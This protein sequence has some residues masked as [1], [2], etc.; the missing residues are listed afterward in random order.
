M[1][2]LA[3]NASE[4]ISFLFLVNPSLEAGLVNPLKRSFALAWLNPLDNPASLLI[5][6]LCGEAKKIF[7]SELKIIKNSD[8]YHTQQ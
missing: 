3:L 4:G 1:A 6:F 2:L 5:F 8:A 7:V